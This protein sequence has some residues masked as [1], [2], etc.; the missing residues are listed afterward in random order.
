MNLRSNG[1]RADTEFGFIDRRLM[2]DRR[3]HPQLIS[4]TDEYSM[5]G[6]IETELKR[7]N[8]FTFS[9]AFISSG[10]LGLLK[11]PLLDFR[12]HGTIIT[13][14]YLGFN[15][16]DMFVEL[17][18]LKNITVLVYPEGKEGFHS[19]GYLFH[20]D[21]GMTAIVGSS[22]L[23]RQALLVNQEWNLKFS[24]MPEGDIT[25]QIEEAVR[26]QSSR[27]A[28]LSQQWVDEYRKNRVVA[29]GP[30]EREA[31]E[32]QVFPR[33]EIVP[34]AMQQRALDEIERLRAEG[35]RRALIVSATGT[36]KTI[37]GALSVRNADPEK[38]LFV[39]HREQ[40][41]D[42]VIE[43]FS[44]VLN[45]G[46]ESFGKVA[47][48]CF[49]A[50]KKYTFAT[51]QSIS[52][53]DV[54]ERF[55]SDAFDYVMVDETH[56]AG[57]KTYA[58]ILE[59]F[60]PSFLL[61]LTATP[62]RMDEFNVYELF[63]YNV[64]CD[65]RLQDA[66]Q[67]GMLCPFNY[68]GVQDYT[69]G[70][71]RTISDTS[72][73]SSLV[74]SERLEHVL[75]MIQVYGHSGPVRGLIFCSRTDE[76]VALAE[77]LTGKIVNGRPLRVESLA[78]TDSISA[79]EDAVGRLVDGKVDY[80][81]TVDI[82]NEG[83]DI[84]SINQVVML[85]ATQSSIIFTQ[86][87]GRGLRKAE[88]KDHLR[89]IDFIGNYKNS[90]LIPMALY[91]NT[92][93]NKDELRARVIDATNIAGVSSVSFDEVARERVIEALNRA[94]I[95]SIS[96]LAKAVRDLGQRIGRVPRLIDLAVHEVVDPLLVANHSS[97]RNYWAFLAKS[98][99][100]S[101]GPDEAESAYLT[102]LSSEV[103]SSK[104]PHEALV[105]LH[106]LGQPSGESSFS[107]LL[108]M[109]E[110]EE[111]G[112]TEESLHSAL[113]VLSY[114]FSTQQERDKYGDYPVVEHEGSRVRLNPKVSCLFSQS[115]RFR[116]HVEDLLESTIHLARHRF[117]WTGELIVGNRYS[118]KDVC[119][120][121][122]WKSNLKG[123]IFGYRVD[124]ATTTCPVFVN[125]RKSDSHSGNIR[126]EDQFDDPSTMTWY[127]KRGVTIDDSLVKELLAPV[128]SPQMYLFVN[129]DAAESKEFYF[130]GKVTPRDAQGEKMPGAGGK[131]HDV[132]SMKLE[133]EQPVEPNLY[134]YFEPSGN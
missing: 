89:V 65:I 7:A 84:P 101:D 63:D 35:A 43:E 112:S 37:L 9:V 68:Y 45:V 13:S 21:D 40:I 15:D 95:E 130:L 124:Y 102:F 58:D 91:G 64:A 126:Y 99:L 56:R 26:A 28:R 66:L 90:F 86:Q 73:L 98:K 14:T 82:F 49:D 83:V 18:N 79:R 30:A 74:M 119:R 134:E 94:R 78:G 132:V 11:Q 72:E 105:V 33:G 129:R 32:L 48:G 121:L 60:R 133:L 69:D 109:L 116:E 29:V 118:R 110:K 51:V 115:L 122:S 44:R 59:H 67:E 107:D 92:S 53:P 75:H 113:L 24:A 131:S 38:F 103:L 25:R 104:R 57:A 50:D 12:G 39:V 127:T 6:A 8:G 10:A 52:R 100:C 70:S 17:M 20:N 2:S 96:S 97:V 71:G 88:G 19:K 27:A 16:P 61:G 62:E 47:G 85:R 93:L 23:T 87:L 55:S 3:K 42:K 125:Y 117:S 81:V 77:W 111:T 123:V 4:N 31:G 54:L 80:L 22:N 46:A 108:D 41:L 1:L 36:G 114:R 34:N 128:G 76:S 106:L 5:L 120:L